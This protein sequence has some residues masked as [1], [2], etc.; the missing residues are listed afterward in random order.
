MGAGE[1]NSESPATHQ[2]LFYGL[3]NFTS[4]WKQ[5]NH[6]KGKL[7]SLEVYP[8]INRCARIDLGWISQR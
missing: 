8:L 1:Q 4:H 5:T 3:K 6:R 2:I 7:A